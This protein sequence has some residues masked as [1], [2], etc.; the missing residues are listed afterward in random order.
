[1]QSNYKKLAF[2]IVIVT[3]IVILSLPPPVSAALVTD[4]ANVDHYAYVNS[5]TYSVT[6]TCDTGNVASVQ[7]TIKNPSG[8]TIHTSELYEIGEGG[9]TVGD[10]VT[11]NSFYNSGDFSVEYNVNWAFWS[12]TITG[13]GA[14]A[15]YTRY[16]YLTVQS[17]Y[18]TVGGYGWKQDGT[19]SWGGLNVGEVSTGTGGKV[20]FTQWTLGGSAWGT[21]YAQSNGITMN[22]E[23]TVIAKWQQYYY[24]TV[25]T[26]HG[27][28]SGANWYASGSAA[29]A[30]VSA[31]TVS[32]GTG[33]QYV[34]AS[35]GGGATGTNYAQ[36]NAI[37]MNAAKTATASWTTQYYLTVSTTYS[38]QT[39]QGWYNSGATAYAGVNN[40][41]VAGGTGTRYVFNSWTGGAYGTTY[42]QS[43]PITMNS[44]KTATATWTTQYYLTVNN[45]GHSTATGAGW[46]NS[47]A[48]ATA[49]VTDSTITAGTTRYV[50]SSWTGDASGTFYLQSNDISMSAPKTATA[51]WTTQ[52]YF[53]IVST[54]GS[55]TGEG[56]YNSGATVNFGVTTPYAGT[57]G[58]QY[59]F[60][61]WTGT[62]SESY[63]GSIA[64]TSITL[65][66]AVVETAAWNTQYYFT[67]STAH[68]TPSG[69]AWYNAGSTVY[70]GVNSGTVSGTTGTQYVFTSWSGAATGSTFSQSDA[71]TLDS[72][73]TATAGWQT[74]YYLTVTST[75]NTPSGEAWYN[76]GATAYAGLNSD[77][78]T[79]H[80]FDHWTNDASGTNYAQSA[81]ITMN[82]PKTAVASWNTLL[83]Y[84]ITAGSSVGGALDPTGLVPVVEGNNQA[85]TITANEGYE[86]TELYIDYELTTISSNISFTFYNVIANHTIYVTFGEVFNETTGTGNLAIGQ[87]TA[88][89]IVTSGNSFTFS[90]TANTYDDYNTLNTTTITLTQG[91]ILT[92]NNLDEFNATNINGYVTFTS[93]ASTVL[94]DTAVRL[95]WTL[96][97]S[98]VLTSGQFN[99]IF[100]EVYDLTNNSTTTSQDNV[101]TF[102][103]LA[104]SSGGGGGGGGSSKP[105]NNTYIIQQTPEPT[106]SPSDIPA[107]L[108]GMVMIVA[109]IAIAIIVSITKSKTAKDL[110][111]E[112]N[113]HSII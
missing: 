62:G 69:E 78:Y 36:S 30:G 25:N 10:T 83:S 80:V 17:A 5:I 40:Q 56:W 44:A 102:I 67:V 104:E 60:G 92:W 9:G 1:M 98:P 38:T 94:N 106:V 50:F 79:N 109:I 51:S 42:S 111:K 6:I 73:K 93:G 64:T 24:L 66:N 13:H 70:A 89:A 99:V 53:D 81:G 75:Y 20:V 59:V 26:N 110:W 97:L 34:F 82:A 4:Y 113:S 54:Y 57:L 28:P 19:T 55:P 63:T 47:G 100:A 105:A 23:K 7:V 52:Y 8:T 91:V 58:T 41:I 45:G 39:G 2:L 16:Y 84:Y 48:V 74:Q 3:T 95:S 18:G 88:P 72:P 31:G 112:R 14:S 32:G 96:T 77:T 90:A 33:I 71:V 22:A 103:S 35:W 68:G 108:L 61:N 37:T 65:N 86:L 43:N 101:F 87:F 11:I 15:S 12:E 76:S 49:G 21:N 46:Y 85:F 107:A 27:T 29:Y